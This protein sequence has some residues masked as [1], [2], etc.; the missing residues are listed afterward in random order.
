M[1]SKAI[2]IKDV[3]KKAWVLV[4]TVSRTFN[5]YIDISDTTRDHKQLNVERFAYCTF[6][7]KMPA[8]DI[9]TLKNWTL[10]L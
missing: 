10:M 3:A 2:T 9:N 1:E 7:S 8:V 5:N 4:S 6:S